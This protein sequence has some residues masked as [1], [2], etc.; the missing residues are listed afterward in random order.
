MRR[1]FGCRS[2]RC[3][4][5]LHVSFRILEKGDIMSLSCRSVLTLRHGCGVLALLAAWQSAAVV[6]AQST[7][8]P[9]SGTVAWTTG[10]AWNGGIPNSVGALAVFPNA[11]TSPSVLSGTVTTG[12]VTFTAG[13]GNLV[14][15]GSNGVTNDV[16]TLATAAGSPT[17]NVN[18]SG[19]R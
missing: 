17:V 13:S 7:W 12:T 11:S 2:I 19:Q 14:M 1:H 3:G 9:T 5:R 10:T 18:G 4:S 6:H 8:L 16:I 15:T